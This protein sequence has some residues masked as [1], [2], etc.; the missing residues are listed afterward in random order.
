M[1]WLGFMQNVVN[2]MGDVAK[3]FATFL[4]R[5]LPMAGSGSRCLHRAIG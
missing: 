3:A 2:Y 4:W 5:R 1:N